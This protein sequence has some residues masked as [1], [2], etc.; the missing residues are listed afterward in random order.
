MH[1]CVCVQ[2]KF[3]FVETLVGTFEHGSVLLVC[4]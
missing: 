3:L 2:Y 4:M 1:A